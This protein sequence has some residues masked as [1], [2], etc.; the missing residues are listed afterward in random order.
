MSATEAATREL[1]HFVGGEWT[2]ASG[3]EIFDDNDPFTGEVVANVAAG[4]REDARRAVEAAAEAFPGW[5]KAPPAE[6]QRA[7]LKA[8]NVLEG[9]QDDVVPWLT[10]ETGSAFGFS[11]FQVQFVASLFRQAAALAYAPIGE[12]IPSDVGQ[13]AMGLRRPVAVEPVKLSLR[14]LGFSTS[15]SPI[16]AAPPGPCVTTFSTPGGSPASPKI[17]AQIRPPLYGESSDGLRT[18]VLPSASGAAMER[19]ERMSAAFQGAIAPTTPTG[20]RS[21]IANWPTSEGIT[22]PMGA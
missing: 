6:K 10:R 14:T 1:H 22:S 16:A 12:V 17:S 21:H 15:S 3:G 8:A 7:F 2:A 20:R 19:A 5:W 13:F 11:M 18:T 9:R 4:T